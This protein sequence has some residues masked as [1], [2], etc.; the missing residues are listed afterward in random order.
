VLHVAVVL[1]AP[2]A[3]SAEN[4]SVHVIMLLN[5]FDEVKRRIPAGGK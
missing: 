1:Q 5:F 3:A 2:E 4:G